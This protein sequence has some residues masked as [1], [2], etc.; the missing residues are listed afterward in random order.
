MIRTT[1][2]SGG[3]RGR[4][5]VRICRNAERFDLG[6]AGIITAPLR[7]CTAAAQGR[8]MTEWA[9]RQRIG[10]RCY[11]FSRELS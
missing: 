6:Q 11:G 7:H 2:I 10:H 9:S 4:I 1:T 5:M 3:V 8:N